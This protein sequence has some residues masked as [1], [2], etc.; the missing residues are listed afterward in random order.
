MNEGVRHSNTADKF[1]RKLAPFPE[2]LH[3][4]ERAAPAVGQVTGCKANL[5]ISQ[6]HLAGHKS[7]GF[8]VLDFEELVDDFAFLVVINLGLASFA[9]LR[10]R[11][12]LCRIQAGNLTA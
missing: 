10:K 6:S 9:K 8:A 1:F 2:L 5:P 3:F 12:E 11:S 7:A 4:L